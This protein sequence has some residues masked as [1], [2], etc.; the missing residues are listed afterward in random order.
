MDEE[1]VRLQGKFLKCRFASD[2]YAVYL[3]T[4]GEEKITVCGPL[5]DI[6][7]QFEYCLYGNYYMHPRYGFQF[8]VDH[9]EKLLPSERE[10]AVRFLSGG[11]FKGIGEKTAVKIV[12]V[13][14]DRALDI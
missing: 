3:F 14:G 1:I 8:Q 7:P 10:E 4:D 2:S 6:D 5:V 12:N 11:F 9:F 13:L